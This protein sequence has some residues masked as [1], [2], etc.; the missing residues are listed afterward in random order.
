LADN[1]AA[2][3]ELRISNPACALLILHAAHKAN[4]LKVNS[5]P[6]GEM[7]SSYGARQIRSLPNTVDGSRDE[8]HSNIRI[9][10]NF[11]GS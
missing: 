5:L 11:R 2:P 9:D 4:T 10:K 6:P 7:Q 8:G 3:L 1:Y